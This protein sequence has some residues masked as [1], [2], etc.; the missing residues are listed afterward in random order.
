MHA[1]CIVLYTYTSVTVVPTLHA[2]AD[3]LIQCLM[4]VYIAKLQLCCNDAHV[5]Y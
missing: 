4:C 3:K 5:Q 1:L 2:C